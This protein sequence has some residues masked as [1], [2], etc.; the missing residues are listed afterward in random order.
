MSRSTTHCESIF[1]RHL[2]KYYFYWKSLFSIFKVIDSRQISMMV[3]IENQ[4]FKFSNIYDKRFFYFFRHLWK[5]FSFFGHLQNYQL[6]LSGK[7]Y[8]F[9]LWSHWWKPKKVLSYFFNIFT[10]FYIFRS[11]AKNKNFNLFVSLFLIF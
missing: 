8:I 11:I 6:F 9:K 7:T 3:F 2:G 5:L 10:N 1:F 4:Y